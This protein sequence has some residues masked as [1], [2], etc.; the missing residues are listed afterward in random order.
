MIDALVF[1]FQYSTPDIEIN[2]D[3]LIFRFNLN[4][5]VKFDILHFCCIAH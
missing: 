5:F 1:V 4:Y 2:I 3:I